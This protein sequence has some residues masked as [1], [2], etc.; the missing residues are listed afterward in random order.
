MLDAAQEGRPDV[1]G[2]APV[3]C[4]DHVTSL[5]SAINCLTVELLKS[6]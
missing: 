5:L 6:L 1:S 4:S 3:E 2:E